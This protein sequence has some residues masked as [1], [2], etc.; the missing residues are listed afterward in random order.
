MLAL[1]ISDTYSRYRFLDFRI[2]GGLQPISNEQKGKVDLVASPILRRSDN[3]GP[4]MRTTI[5][6]GRDLKD[7]IWSLR[8]NRSAVTRLAGVR[9]STRTNVLLGAEVQLVTMHIQYLHATG[10]A[11]IGLPKRIITTVG[12]DTTGGGSL[13][14]MV[15]WLILTSCAN[16]GFDHEAMA[17]MRDFRLEVEYHALKHD[18]FSIN[19]VHTQICKC[20]IDFMFPAIFA[21]T[22]LGRKGSIAGANYQYFPAS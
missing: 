1:W 9:R 6:G 20:P 14:L 5:Q 17:F 8:K 19:S 7:T 2:P 18:D 22:G 16:K 10:G 4:L 15:C 11:I 12:T 21:R 3:T 13:R